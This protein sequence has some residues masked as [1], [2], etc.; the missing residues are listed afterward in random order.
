LKNLTDKKNIKILGKYYLDNIYELNI[1]KLFPYLYL[2]DIYEIVH[3]GNDKRL[4]D[5][6]SKI[7]ITEGFI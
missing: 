7:M 5:V 6:K 3:F 1:L 2:D 4:F